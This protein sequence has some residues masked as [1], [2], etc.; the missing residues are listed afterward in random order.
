MGTVIIWIGLAMTV[1]DWQCAGLF[2]EES[3]EM[4]AGSCDGCE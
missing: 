3:E 4:E 1:G 2:F